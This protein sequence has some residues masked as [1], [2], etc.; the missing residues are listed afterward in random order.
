L[1][2]QMVNLQLMR[3]GFDPNYGIDKHFLDE[4][5][6]NKNKKIIELETFDFQIKLFNQFSDQLQDLFLFYTVRDLDAIEKQIGAMMR[7]WR[8]GDAVAMND[9]IFKEFKETQKL[10]PLYE[11]L[12]YERNINMLSKIEMLLKS[13]EEYFIVIGA[14]HLV[15][16]D[17]IINRLKEKGY[18]VEQL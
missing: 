4:A 7:A 11:K 17:G 14:G 5:G 3:L 1:A 18:S 9:L 15:G 16:E 13:K 6:G 10:S 12:F 8:N 2:I